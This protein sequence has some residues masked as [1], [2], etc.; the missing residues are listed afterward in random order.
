MLFAMGAGSVVAGVSS[1]D[2]YPPE[3][4][5]LPKLGGLLD[6]N[7]ERLLALKPDL[8]IV[9]STQSELKQQ[10]ERAGIAMFP[11]LHRG[12]TDVTTTI[13]ALGA[14]VGFAA[15]ANAL[16]DGMERKLGEIRSRVA[17]RPR[18]RTLLVFGRQQGTLQNIDASGGYGFLHDMLEA[19]GG[20]DAVG[21]VKR[22]SVQMTTEMV[23]A[24]APD[25]IV[26]LHYSA[27]LTPAQME[28]EKHV[29]DALGSVPAVRNHRVY[30][31]VGDEYVVP[32]PRLVSATERLARLLHPDAFK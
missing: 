22:E 13:R 7:V 10:M 27:S 32:G 12:L 31:V 4:A 24:R 28:S 2:R 14:R 1:Y 3:V 15:Q 16:A 19:A 20:A 23:L 6:P 18:P 29:W 8:V 30:L 21:D 25:V 5:T 9:Y 26:E 11:Y 17:G